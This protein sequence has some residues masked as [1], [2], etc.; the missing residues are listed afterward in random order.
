MLWFSGTQ[1]AARKVVWNVFG[2]SCIVPMILWTVI[3]DVVKPNIKPIL[4]N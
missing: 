3:Q 1:R 2:R 4:V